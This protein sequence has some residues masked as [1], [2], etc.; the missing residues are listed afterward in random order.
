MQ[1]LRITFLIALA[2]ALAV[3]TTSAPTTTLKP[4]ATR[5]DLQA[6]CK[7]AIGEPRIEELGDGVWIAIGYDLNN[8]ILI[9]TP[10]GSV[11]VDP[12]LSPSR[13]QKIRAAFG[14]RVVLPITA[15]IYTHSHIDHINAAG[16]WA[17]EK[18]N[19]WATDAFRDHFIKQY[20]IYQKVEAK[21]GSRQ[22]GFGLSD[23]DAPCSALGLRIDYAE[24]RQTQIRLP[25]HTFSGSVTIDFGGRKIELVE[26]HGETDDQLFVWIPDTEVLLPGDNFYQAFPNLYTIRGTRP[27]PV[28]EWIASLDKMRAYDPVALGPSHTLAL[29][30]RE[31]IRRQLTDYRDAI[32]WVKDE[33]VRRANSGADIDSI[34]ANV[35]L[36]PHL[37]N[38]PYLLELYGQVDWSARAIYSNDLGWFDGRAEA[39]YPL[40]ASEAARREIAAMGGAAKVFDT[41]RQ[42]LQNNDPQWSLHLLSKLRQAETDLDKAAWAAATAGA[43][44]AIAANVDNSNGRSYLLVSANELEGNGPDLTPVTPPDTLLRELPTRMFLEIM[45]SRLLPAESLNTHESVRF[46]FSDSG[47]LYFLTIRNGIAEL[48][49]GQALPGTPEPLA[50]VKTDTLTWKRLAVKAENAPA[51]LISGRLKIAGSKTGFLKFIDRFDR[52]L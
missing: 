37:S 35:A 41:A 6:H 50:T 51:A 45:A 20:G 5:H 10:A 1:P 28:G 27:R 25:T 2:L 36:P 52:S 13:A 32:Q 42:A 47:E 38:K 12:G 39:L 49:S 24:V 19:I 29:K 9:R 43:L 33:V 34:V 15:I 44:R 23:N 18:T 4:A 40:A 16:V 48:V 17:E 3:C 26:A 22:F 21:R 11:V 8:T 14:E 30:G 7:N 31:Q 46:E